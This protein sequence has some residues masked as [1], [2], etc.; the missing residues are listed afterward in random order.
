M[1]RGNIRNANDLV[2]DEALVRI[3]MKAESRWF[4]RL[5]WP[6]EFDTCVRTR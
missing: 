1:H 2:V 4:D 5:K 6:M 3:G